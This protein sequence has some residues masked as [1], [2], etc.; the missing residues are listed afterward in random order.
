MLHQDPLR[1]TQRGLSHWGAPDGGDPRIVAG[2]AQLRQLICDADA[3]QT[4]WKI[5]ANDPATQQRLGLAGPVAGPLWIPG[6]SGDHVDVSSMRLPSVEAEIALVL[7]RAVSPD[8][9]ASAI[10]AAIESVATAA[11]LIDLDQRFDDVSLLIGRNF[12]HRRHFIATPDERCSADALASAF[13][14]VS[15]NGELVWQVPTGLILGD[16][17]DIVRCAAMN[18]AL[19]G[20]VLRPGDTIL[21]GVVTP[22]PVWVRNGDCVLVDGGGLGAVEIGF[23]AIS[24]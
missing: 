11:E 20:K 23:G 3:V 8:E 12:L 21:S 15:L 4:G 19:M 17:V 10:A 7:S 22:L 18:V 6:R 9:E 1:T 14:K 16:P 13:F 5:A 24:S 2:F